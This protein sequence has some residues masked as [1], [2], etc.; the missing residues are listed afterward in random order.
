MTR[1]YTVNN[2]M[3]DEI[4]KTKDRF[5][6]QKIIS[7]L[8]NGTTRVK[9]VAGKMLGTN[10][11]YSS[12]P[13]DGAL[14][15]S[16]SAG[17]ILPLRKNDSVADITA[18]IYNLMVQTS[19][20]K[21]KHDEL[22]KKLVFKQ[23]K[24]S[25]LRHKQL[26]DALKNAL[27]TP[28]GGPGPEGPPSDTATS[29]PWLLG[30]AAA[31]L[32]LSPPRLR[33]WKSSISAPKKTKINYTP[34]NVTPKVGSKATRLNPSV[35]T[36]GRTPSEKQVRV[37]Q[38]RGYEFN[39]GANQFEKSKPQYGPN[40]KSVVSSEQVKKL[41]GTSTFGKVSKRYK[42]K[43]DLF[44]K[45]KYVERFTKWF[46]KKLRIVGFATLAGAVLKH[47]EYIAG[48]NKEF[49]DEK[50]PHY[51][52]GDWLQQQVIT[53][54]AGCFTGLVA[55]DLGYMLGG[56]VGT[57]L[58][59]PFGALIGAGVG[60]WAG[61][62]IGE[63]YAMQLA[64][65]IFENP[66]AIREFESKMAAKLLD[67]SKQLNEMMGFEDRFEKNRQEMGGVS[68]VPAQMT[69]IGKMIEQQKE[70]VAKVPPEMRAAEQQKL[71]ALLK[72]Q[73]T[74]LMDTK[75]R[76]VKEAIKA[77]ERNPNAIPQKSN[78]KQVSSSNVNDERMKSASGKYTT[79][80]Y[81]PSASK[82]TVIT[83]NKTAAVKGPE[84]SKA[85]VARIP[86]RQSDEAFERAVRKSI[87]SV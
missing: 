38:R 13:D 73:K 21:I 47:A 12:S 74:I 37:M 59:G 14:F 7:F 70:R 64:T 27:G 69:D 57:I 18:K 44:N 85:V 46:E 84:S 10:E 49:E 76:N 32:A 8:T 31:A 29:W 71:D 33:P 2:K 50:S 77:Y 68:N 78:A 26:M 51:Q 87:V 58:G 63:A 15:T 48:A 19:L 11:E 79:N 24:A 42:N 45:I 30:G 36:S 83:N 75:H 1:A 41:S 34:K 65:W 66:D 80:Q 55:G 54:L 52:D 67:T 40:K 6:L 25:D 28:G 4:S 82:P 35:R 72:S 5:N 23:K 39:K 9:D 20:N 62:M 86:V 53:S 81:V 16:I 43:V 17:R 3:Q 56:A 22:N 61:F 60:G